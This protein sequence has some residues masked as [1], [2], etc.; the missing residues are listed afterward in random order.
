MP[1]SPSFAM[2]EV[3]PAKAIDTMANR[4]HFSK[5]NSVTVGAMQR[6]ARNGRW[7]NFAAL[8]ANRVGRCRHRHRLW[9]VVRGAPE[10]G[11]DFDVSE[12]AHKLDQRLGH[13][14]GRHPG[15]STRDG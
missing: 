10:T 3:N 2:T 5:S 1:L 15:Q 4:T 12:F 11:R 8:G 6:L 9:N 13:D 14:H 7:L